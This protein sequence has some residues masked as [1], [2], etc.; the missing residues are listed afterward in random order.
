MPIRGKKRVIRSK[1]KTIRK[2]E[3]KI[4]VRRKSK[5]TSKISILEKSG[6]LG[7]LTGTGVTSENYKDFF[8]KE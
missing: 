8:H 2:G 4:G 5:K 6:L 3:K 7:S 1:R